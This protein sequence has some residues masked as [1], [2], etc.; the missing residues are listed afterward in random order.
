MRL[1]YGN[2][3]GA[4][5]I[6]QL[7]G[8]HL[9]PWHR[10]GTIS[11]SRD[12]Y[13]EAP[14]YTG[15][16]VT[17]DWCIYSLHAAPSQLIHNL[18]IDS[19][20]YGLVLGDGQDASLVYNGSALAINSSLVAASDIDVTCGAN[21]TVELQ[22]SVY[23]DIQF[24]TTT[25]KATPAGSAP[26]WEAFTTNTNE[27]AF[28]VDEEWEVQCNEISHWVKEGSTGHIHLHI[29]PKTA[30]AT[31]ANRFAKFTVYFAAADVDEV[32]AESGPYTAEYTIP[33]GTAALT[34]LYLDMG[35]IDFST[36]KIGA[37]MKAKIKRIAATGGTEYADSVFVTQCGIHF[38]KNTMGSRNETTK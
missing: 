24:A 8:L 33:T 5:T 25:G 34:H 28:D 27:Y 20:T 37:Q 7:N 2:Y 14:V 19:D 11:V 22:N 9:R 18:N 16:T 13:I 3:V 30:N 12:I 36:F 15:A 4:I 29:A 35:N 32:W 23:D 31:G 21:K 1:N 17:N 38:E 6:D 10:Q 26:N